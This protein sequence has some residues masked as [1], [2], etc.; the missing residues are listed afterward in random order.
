MRMCKS[1]PFSLT[2]ENEFSRS[3]EESVLRA[4]E[5]DELSPVF[6]NKKDAIMYLQKEASSTISY[7]N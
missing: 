1:I 6:K 2:T 7:D 3:F 4:E 5:N